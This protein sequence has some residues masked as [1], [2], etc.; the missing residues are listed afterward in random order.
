M[1]WGSG[2]HRWVPSLTWQCNPR[3]AGLL[4]GCDARSVIV[5]L[6][7]GGR[8][9]VPSVITVDFCRHPGTDIVAD[10]TDTPLP[11]GSVDLVISTGTLEHVHSEDGLLREIARILRPG[12]RAHI[13]VPFLQQYHD[14]PIDSRRYT[15][16]GLQE[17]MQRYGLTPVESGVH[18]GPSVT[19]I[20]LLSYYAAL[21]FEGPTLAH[22]IA[23]YGALAATS[24]LLAPLKY[25]DRFLARKKGAHRLAFGVFCTAVKA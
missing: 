7:A 6:G 13:E 8:R 12:G 9:V 21:I 20:T 1:P 14:D 11:D 24:W 18:I 4:R 3:I 19:I 2:N 23:S 16:P 25:L 17:F 10:I 15:L 5:D 22:R